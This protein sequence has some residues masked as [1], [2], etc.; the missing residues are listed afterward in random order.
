MAVKEVDQEDG[1]HLLSPTPSPSITPS[2]MRVSPCHYI[3]IISIP[4]LYSIPVP[5]PIDH[6][7]NHT[8]SSLPTP[9]PPGE[10]L[11]L[12]LC[13]YRT[14][15]HSA[16]GPHLPDQHPSSAGAGETHTRVGGGQLE[17]GR[18]PDAEGHTEAAM[19]AHQ[20]GG[21][22]GVVIFIHWNFLWIVEMMKV[23][24]QVA[25]LSNYGPSQVKSFGSKLGM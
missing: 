1:L 17:I 9:A 10:M 4:K 6:T 19:S 21:S 15:H 13:S 24:Q 12:C 25:L 8:P 14:L 3:I 20:V 22:R 2:V 11:W 18:S 16:Q 7:S 23:L 5:C